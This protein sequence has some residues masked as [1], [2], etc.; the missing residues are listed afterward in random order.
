MLLSKFFYNNNGILECFDSTV[1]SCGEMNYEYSNPLTL[2]CF[3]S[4]E[5]CFNKNNNYFF[6]KYCYKD[7]CSDNIALSSISDETIKNDFITNLN[8]E[9][10]YLNKI[11]VCNIFNENVKWDFS[12]SNEGFKSQKCL[13]ECPDEYE[14]NAISKRCIESCLSY[15]HYMFNDEC[16][17][18]GFPENTRQS[19]DN[20]HICICENYFSNND[21]NQLECYNTLEDCQNNNLLYYNEDANQCFSSLDN[22]FSNNFNYFFNKV[23][24]NDG[25]PIGKIVLSNIEDDAIKSA[26]IN[27]LGINDSII[28]KIC[29][30]DIISDENLKWTYDP[31]NELQECV[32]ICDGELYEIEPETITHKCIDKCNPLADFV[33]NNICYKYNCPIGT[34]LKNDGKRNCICENYYYINDENMMVCCTRENEDDENCIEKIIY[35]P[36]YYKN[37]D[38]CLAVYNNTCY[39]RC[40]E[41]ICLTQKD[42]NL[43]YCIRIREYMTVFNDICF[44]NFDAIELNVKNI[45]DNDIYIMPSPNITI[46]AYST[47]TEI[48]EINSNYSYIVLG[49][50]EAA[51]KEYFHLPNDTILYILGVETPNKNK[52]SSVNVYNYGVYLGNGTQLNISVC[53]MEEITI[54]ST[55]TNTSLIKLKEA[56]YF[57]SYGYDIY[58]ESNIFYNDVCS[59]TSIDGNDITLNDRYIDFYP[60]DITLC[61]DTYE[62]EMVN[63]TSEKI[64]CHCK[65]NYNY[66][67]NVKEDESEEE[68]YLYTHLD[69]FLSLVNYKIIF[70]QKLLLTPSN[71]LYNIGFYISVIITFICA[72]LMFINIYFGMISLNSIINKNEPSKGKLTEKKKEIIKRIKENFNDI[73][74][75]KN[76][77]NR[78]KGKSKIINNPTKRKNTF[79]KEIKYRVKNL[80]IFS[81]NFKINEFK[82]KICENNNKKVKLKDKLTNSHNRQKNRKSRPKILTILTKRKISDNDD[83]N[84][85]ITPSSDVNVI[86]INKLKISSFKKNIRGKRNNNDVF[87]MKQNSYSSFIINNDE[88]IDIKDYNDVPYTQA[89]RIDNRT[90]CQ[91]FLYVI[92]K[93]IEFI[94]IFYYKSEYVHLS[95]NISLYIFD[96]LLDVAL[97]C[98]LY[99]DDVVSEKYLNEG[100]LGTF[101]SLSLSLASN[102][103]SSIIGYFLGKLGEYTDIFDMVI[104]HV[105]IKRYYYLNIIKFRKYLKL[106]LSFFY[107][108]QFIMCLLMAYYI[109]IFCIIYSK[110][111]VSVV[112][113]Y[114]YGI[115]ESLAISIG[116]SIIITLMRFISIK[117]KYIQ[118]YRTSQYLYN[119]F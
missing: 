100:S 99:T 39:S 71:Y 31:F 15:R 32:N 68:E 88:S 26:F 38:K 103:I 82:I 76:K 16:Y 51:L 112:F 35:P 11:C 61:N 70:C 34:K 66:T 3:I 40:P 81:K 41:G 8:I 96:F 115:L 33:F 28:D 109:T 59:P 7:T 67:K 58:N 57:Y 114:I 101:T 19:E 84:T 44:L 20:E 75:K 118:I 14:P 12:V 104:K 5:N 37:P 9:N 54:F 60:S 21:V 46:K 36:E 23:C 29:V 97:N 30:C 89:L 10:E 1:T 6:N 2:E 55:I 106:R 80:N 93:K 24:Y 92:A 111:Q 102:V 17:F 87:L 91:I 83:T 22:C 4:L 95:M 42:I 72:I 79:S 62:F 107:I 27:I 86:K 69:Y 105:T 52:K 90:I 85:P 98:F 110:S 116:L 47:E 45:S 78:L 113:N 73:S 63:L 77:I 53:S 119:K 56:N 94:N 49:E 25:C 13:T 18:E 43:V 117:Y 108:I 74:F 48:N 65:I 64:K 50:C